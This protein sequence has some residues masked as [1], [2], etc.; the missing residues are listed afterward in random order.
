MIGVRFLHVHVGGYHS[1]LILFCNVF[2]MVT[3]RN[4][5]LMARPVS[6]CSTDTVCYSHMPFDAEL[7]SLISAC[8]CLGG[9]EMQTK[10]D[11]LLMYM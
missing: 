4:L 10:Y 6:L 3:G 8:I 7:I 2:S 1:P 11:S 5:M 9:L